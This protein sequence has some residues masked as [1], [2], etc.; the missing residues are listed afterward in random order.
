M[1]MKK[2]RKI[3]SF[4]LILALVIGL[5]PAPFGEPAEVLAVEEPTGPTSGTC[6]DNITWELTEDTEADWDLVQGKP[7]KLTLTGSG[8]MQNFSTNNYAPWYEYSSMITSVSIAEGITTVGRYAFY[9]CVSLKSIMIPDSVVVIERFAFQ[10]CYQLET[11]E[12]GKGLKRIGDQAFDHNESLTTIQFK[13]GLETIEGNAFLGCS[14]LQDITLPDSVTTLDSFVFQSAGLTSF[15]LPRNVT[16]D[17]IGRG[18]LIGNRHLQ[19]IQV[20]EG[21]PYFAVLDNIL[22]EMKDGIPYRAI[23]C[24]YASLGSEISIAEG[25][26]IING[27]AFRSADITSVILPDTLK[28]IQ[29]EAF[30]YCR[31]LKEVNIPDSVENLESEVFF[32]CVC[33]E[34]VTIGKGLQELEGYWNSIFTKC[35]KLAVI[36]VSEENPYLDS[37]D[38][39]VYNKEHTHL[40]VYAPARLNTE[41][42]IPDTVESISPW[43][44]SYASNLKA[45][46]ISEKITTIPRFAIS[47]NSKLQDIYFKGSAPTLLSVG[48]DR[49]GISNNADNLI[50]YRAP[51]ST[52]WDDPVWSNYTLAEWDPKN[53]TQEEGTLGNI[54]W[55]YE[56]D[57]GRISFIGKGDLPDFTEENPAPWSSYVESIQKIET[58]GISGIGNYAFSNAANLLRLET[59]AELKRIGDYAFSD[60]GKLMYF[61]IAAAEVIGTRAFQNAISIRNPLTLEKVSSIGSGAFQGC[62]ALT[63]AILGNC[64]V[65]LEE[66]VFR[67]CTALNSL[68]IP[69]SVTDIKAG[70]LKDCTSLRTI[71]IPASVDVIGTQVFS[72]DAALE[73]VYFYGDIPR[74]WSEDSFTGCSGDLT[75]YYR[76]TQTEWEQLNGSWNGLNLVGLDRFYTEGQDHYSFA[77]RASSFGYQEDYRVPR[78]RYVDVLDSIATGTY[79]YA[80][81]KYWRGSSYGMAATTLEFYENRE[82]SRFQIKNY[83]D[84]AQ[85]LYNIE[86]PSTALTK[87]I[88][89]YQISQYKPSISGFGGAIRKNMGDYREMIQKV[90]EFERS[91]G[92]RTDDK[93]EPIIMVIYSVFGANVVIPVSVD[94]A[95]NG[96]FL[97]KVYDPNA[98]SSLQPLTIYRDF[99]G[100]S[101]G[102]YTYASY[103]DY[104]VTANAMSGIQL[105]DNT[106]DGSIYLS[107]DK[108]KGTVVNAEGKTID[109]IEGAYEQKP[110]NGKGEDDFSGIRSFVLPEGNYKFTAKEDESAEETKNIGE[111]TETQE[112]VTFYL[113]SADNC[114]E[115]TSSDKEA[116][117]EVQGTDTQSGG[118]EIKLQSESKTEGTSSLTLVNQQGMERTIE[119]ESAN[120]AVMIAQDNTITVQVPTDET[121]SIDGKKVET[122]NGQAVSSFEASA[123]ENPFKAGEFE[124]SVICDKYNKLSGNANATV[125]SNAASAKVVAIKAEY[126]DKNGKEVASYSEKT[127]LNGG[128]NKVSLSFE[129]LATAFEQEEGDTDLS[130]RLTVTDENN[131]SVVFTEKDIKVTLTKQPD[132]TT[133]PVENVTVN[134][135]QVTLGVG[136]SFQLE[137]SVVPENASDKAITFESSDDNII[138]SETGLVTANKIG[139]SNITVKSSNGKYVVV[140]VNVKKAPNKITLN[141]QKKTLKIG[142]SFQIKV[143]LPKDTASNKITYSSDKMSVA[144]VS[145]AGKVTAKKKGAATITVKTFNG[146]TAKLKITVSNGVDV[147]KV[148]AKTKKLIL[149]VG[150]SFKLE[151]SVSP[152]NATN[153]KLTFQASNNK[154]TVNSKG[155]ITAK[156]AGD[157][158]ITVKSIN[159]KK[160]VVKVTVKKAPKKITLNAKKKTLRVGK[161][162]KIKATLPKN[163]ASNKIIYSSSKKSVASVS[164]SGKVK[165]KKKGTATITV[166]TF[167]GKKATLKIIVR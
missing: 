83:T 121:V 116:V 95:D 74:N 163:T 86:R 134:S 25:T 10:E 157:A 100:I 62:M 33:L 140:Q 14:A 46:Y 120:T 73:K 50:I 39:V 101:Y 65:S 34:K 8:E 58:H 5:L 162:Y 79:Y 72:G 105:H 35:W 78:Q 136:E 148:T 2:L 11:V 128:L 27:M 28:S 84:T 37:I 144:S 123:K 75:L 145:F 56:G 96:D 47:Y 55:N 53:H 24:A 88:E 142:K 129:S 80:I 149:G 15:T 150:E 22:Y 64:L 111:K 9:E 69:E 66:D 36:T 41:Y 12:C 147:K 4:L 19:R 52:G 67:G 59:D 76:K 48:N 143:S 45:L 16:P 91:G 90:E 158:K 38:N 139:S 61:D 161:S 43:S 167:N 110:L 160:A 133:I 13:D 112:N 166:K 21:N 94:Q 130:C 122:E 132:N 115:I 102:M 109:E 63:E 135:K 6:G 20:A 81:S 70:A 97:L 106:V 99:S 51:D 141:A 29:T 152:I 104:T 156:K 117:L 155:K 3:M 98:P 85:T 87:L 92:L 107:I 57:I 159:G 1:R 125:I 26:E 31:G 42:H 108:E 60:C 164:S 131:N 89:G 126:F 137:T 82:D 44:I 118:L 138:V 127:T 7:Y 154:V 54:S 124:T 49:G 93:A 114:A 151:T 71:N 77:N 153:K 18:I 17:T 103:V 23:A 119:V 32:E 40:Y 165:G 68:I 146:K 30:G 113:A